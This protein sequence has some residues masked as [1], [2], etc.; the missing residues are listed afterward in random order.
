MSSGG[1]YVLGTHDEEIARLDLQ[2]R[3]WRPDVFAAWQT[4]GIGR[5]QT[6]LDVGCGPGYASL[7]LADTVGPLGHVVAI[8]KSERFLKVLESVRRHNI[9]TH[10]ADLEAGEFPQMA[11]HSVWCR[12]VL[13]FVRNPRAVLANM[14]AA[15]E[16]GGVIVLHEY[17]GYA[18]WRASPPCTELEEFVTAVMT[19]WRGTGGEPDIAL[20][21]PRWLEDLGFELRRVRPIVNV[22]ERDS[23][24]WAWLRGFIH[25]GRQRLTDL[26]Y[27]EPS[28]SDRIWEAFTAF[29]ATPRSRMF[30]P[31]VLEI[32]AGR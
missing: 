9:T 20:Q 14:A 10:R 8:D 25:V 1:E 13:C 21:L 4:A 23:M 17:F 24:L 5:S 12:W 31:G 22:V 3:A 15:L 32:I 26:G 6:V 30:T 18:S 19:S 28:R 2:H 7:D 16:P 11:A 27:L 29:E